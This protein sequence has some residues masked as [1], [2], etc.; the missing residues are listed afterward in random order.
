MKTR[1]P[2][3][4][5]PDG[6]YRVAW[7]QDLAPGDVRPLHYFGKD[8]VLFRTESGQVCVFDAH[9]PHLGAHLGRGGKVIGETIQCPFHGWCMDNTGQCVQIPYSKKIPSHA[10]IN[11]WHVNEVN[12]VIYAYHHHANKEPDW[13]VPEQEEYQ[14]PE[15]VPFQPGAR[16]RIRTHLQELGENGMDKAHFSYLH[17]QQTKNMRSESI[18]E[19]GHIFIHRTF[20]YYSV[21]GL[22]KLFID[23]VSGPLDLTLYGMGTAVNRTCVDARIKL[24]YTFIF[25]FTPIDLEHTEVTCM[26]TMK[27][28]GGPLVTRMLMQKAIK[29]GQRTI[30]QDVP[31]WENKIYRNKPILC[32][33][34][35][36]IMRYRRWAR[37][38]Y[39]E[40][41]KQEN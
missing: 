21:F 33:G 11:N 6:W 13:F 39:E 37:Q 7:A 20:Q 25:F 30:D 19:D 8:L 38:F 40:N 22:A 14:S 27:K 1:F 28:T 17:P 3:T 15:W 31:I 29:E 12:G 9:C 35:G 18:E 10:K 26:L 32:D 24:Y 41:N 2:F 34:D 23:E 16:W 4:S 36:P 5:Y